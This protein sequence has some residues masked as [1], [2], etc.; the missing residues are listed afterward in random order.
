MNKT[1]PKLILNDEVP[2]TVE[3]IAASIVKLSQIGQDLN[4]S[5]LNERAIV[6]L[7]HDL[8]GL[9]YREIKLVLNSLAEL[10]KH[11]TKKL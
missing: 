6:V 3:I 2:E 11:Y 8:T 7:L 5:A 4:K 1:K 10:E 9:P